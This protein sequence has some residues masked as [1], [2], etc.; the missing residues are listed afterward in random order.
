M[1][2]SNKLVKYFL[3]FTFVV[4]GLSYLYYTYFSKDNNEK[5][6]N[7]YINKYLLSLKSYI[8]QFSN[9]LWKYNKNFLCIM[10]FII[11]KILIKIK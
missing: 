7:E 9:E 8:S 6:I 5:Y 11:N 2:N 3:G 10:N 4:G 1:D